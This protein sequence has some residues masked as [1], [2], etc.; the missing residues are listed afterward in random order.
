MNSLVNAKR[1]LVVKITNRYS[2]LQF[3]AEHAHC[4]LD[5]LIGERRHVEEVRLLVAHWCG[6]L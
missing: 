6:I 3:V 4:E 2:L 5:D 1:R